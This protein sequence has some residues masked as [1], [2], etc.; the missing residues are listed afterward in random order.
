MTGT[1]ALNRHCTLVGDRKGKQEV[2]A[3]GVDMFGYGEN[4]AEVVSWVAQASRRQE[5]VEQ[6]WIAHQDR[7]EECGLI[8]RRPATADK[9][10]GGSSAEFFGVCPDCPD[11]LTIECTDGTG[12]AVEHVA[13]QCR[14]RRGADIGQG[15][16][17]DEIRD[18]IHDVFVCH[19]DCFL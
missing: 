19:H 6:I 5:C 1:C 7:I 11:E 10:C 13:F 8:H 16:V 2:G 4:R 15:C 3:A 9:G 12:D 14:Q 18:L 17:D